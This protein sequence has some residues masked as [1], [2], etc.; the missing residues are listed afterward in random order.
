ML[1][2]CIV[3]QPIYSATGALQGY[4]IRF[5]DSEDGRDAFTQSLLTGT[6]DI[7]RSGIPAYVSC[8]RTQLLEDR[9]SVV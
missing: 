5:R 7:V 4:E 3:R 8:S 2:F 6:F 9:K 1:D